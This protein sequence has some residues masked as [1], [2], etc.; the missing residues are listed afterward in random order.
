MATSTVFHIRQYFIF[1]TSFDLK[2]HFSSAKQKI[3]NLEMKTRLNQ[4]IE[5]NKPTLK[6]NFTWEYI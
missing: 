2:I 1:L 3:T 6:F 4:K 5:E